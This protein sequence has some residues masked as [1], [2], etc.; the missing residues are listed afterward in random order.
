MDLQMIGHIYCSLSQ[1][2]TRN[3]LQKGKLRDVVSPTKEEDVQLSD[4]PPPQTTTIFEVE[5]K[6]L[7]PIMAPSIYHGDCQR[8]ICTIWLLE[9]SRSTFCER[10][11][12]ALSS[13]NEW[14]AIHDK[15]YQLM[16]QASQ[17]SFCNNP[18]LSPNEIVWNDECL[19]SDRKSVVKLVHKRTALMKDL[20]H[21]F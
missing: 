15:R 18:R 1:F 14:S 5:A 20:L 11:Y 12:Q 7:Q 17:M 4:C 19:A 8:S 3:K 21:K 9:T 13:S 2:K 6:A 10:G 16:T